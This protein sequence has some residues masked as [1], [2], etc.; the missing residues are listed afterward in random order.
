MHPRTRFRARCHRRLRNFRFACLGVY[1]SLT[2]P[3]RKPGWWAMCRF[4]STFFF[5]YKTLDRPDLAIRFGRLWPAKFEM[6]VN[7][8]NDDGDRRVRFL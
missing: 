8:L 1:G 3:F 2:F 4:V 7:V 6:C 5:L